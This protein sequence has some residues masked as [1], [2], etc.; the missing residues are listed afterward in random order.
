MQ[1]ALSAPCQ[2]PAGRRSTKGFANRVLCLNQSS[3]LGPPRRS[4]FR[5]RLFQCAANG[6][7][8]IVVR[9]ADHRFRSGSGLASWGQGQTELRWLWLGLSLWLFLG[10]ML[11]AGAPRPAAV[12]LGATA[13]LVGVLSFRPLG[14]GI[15]AFALF[16]CALAAWTALSALPLPCWVV[17]WLAPRSADIWHS[18]LSP[19]GSFPG[20]CA[21]S[22]APAATVQSALNLASYAVVAT[23]AGTLSRRLGL[24]AVLLSVFG[25]AVLVA[26]L[27]L[28]HG[29][30][31]AERLFGLSSLPAKSAIGPASVL[32]N[33]NNL[34]AYMNLG[35]FC[36]LSLL[37][38]RR[39]PIPRSL[40]VVGG[41]L[42]VATALLSASRGGVLALAF[43]MLA[44]IVLVVARRFSPRHRARSE[45]ARE[46]PLLLVV[47]A[48]GV[49]IAILGSSPDVERELFGSD[50]GKLGQ[51]GQLA[52][53]L[54]EIGWAGT[55]RGAFDSLSAA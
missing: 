40:L 5:K 39:P 9:H 15:N 28:A 35:T 37:V 21:V 19:L 29:L 45:S 38:S 44:S 51:L 32:V 22:V 49:A 55:G 33:P 14:T 52:T 31:G 27:T 1:G 2:H 48:A 3:G 34:A 17:R 7:S 25:V 16:F 30:L 26:L 50:V 54:D 53:R 42:C 43:G 23:A 41:G 24:W 47:L 6:C 11:L 18:A 36:G 10:A 4:R 46:G 12:V 20:Y 13:L 8:V